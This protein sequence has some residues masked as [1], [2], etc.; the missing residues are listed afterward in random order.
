MTA[1]TS[2]VPEHLAAVQLL[3]NRCPTPELRK[4]FVVAAA[5]HDA[6]T[7]EEAQL[8]ISANQLETA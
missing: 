2:A 5:C 6:I 7:G 8:L 4:G 3:V 1:V